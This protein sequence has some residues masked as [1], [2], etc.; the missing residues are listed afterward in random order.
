MG[1]VK[2]FTFAHV[3]EGIARQSGALLRSFYEKGV[4]AE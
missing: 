2:K 4:A 3:A 1:M